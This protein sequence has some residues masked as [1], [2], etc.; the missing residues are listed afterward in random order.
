MSSSEVRIGSPPRRRL[1][2]TDMT[3]CPLGFGASSLG[4]VFHDTDDAESCDVVRTA[5]DNGVNYIDTAPWYGQGKSETILGRVLPH[6]PR[7]DFYVA[8]KVG[9]YERDV[10]KMFDF[11]AERTLASVD[12]SLARLRLPYVDVIQVH[13][14]EFA[15]S[16]DVVVGETLPALQKVKESGKAR[17]IGVTGYPLEVLADVVRR[18]PVHI[19]LVLSYCR[20]S[21][22][23]TALLDYL[24]F[25]AERGV[26]VVSASPLSM[27]LLTDRGPPSWH[28]ATDEIKGACAAAASYARERGVDVSRLAL[29][30][31]L[32]NDAI[33]VTLVSTASASNMRANLL[34]AGRPLS[35]DEREVQLAISER[36][37]RP[38]AVKHWEGNEVAKYWRSLR[39]A[40]AAEP[41]A[42]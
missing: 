14:V 41:A 5:V 22:N 12:E 35:A 23:D 4:S 37:M 33:P 19:D 13:D 36:F 40:A 1:G 25:F 32:E 18:S 10:A 28:P 38:I 17:Y 24:P 11:S 39:D 31:A 30:F 42:Q 6:L 20:Y 3:V 21:L 8:T 27:G 7:A 16:V 26:A 9:R 15:P 2:A 29:H 34:T